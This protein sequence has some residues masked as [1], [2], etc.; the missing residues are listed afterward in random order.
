MS[1]TFELND[2]LNKGVSDIVTSA[3]K[4]SLRNPGQL[5]FFVK[6]SS[7]CQGSTKE[8]DEAGSI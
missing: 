7:H 8:K 4:A 2:Y 5:V 1:E 3:L 6:V